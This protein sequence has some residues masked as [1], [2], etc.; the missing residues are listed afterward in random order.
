MQ[1]PNAA[2]EECQTNEQGKTNSC[3]IN[4]FDGLKTVEQNCADNM[5]NL[6]VHVLRAKVK[7]KTKNDITKE[8]GGRIQLN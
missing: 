3:L 5:L 1:G 7:T 2:D 4:T 6:K 8:I